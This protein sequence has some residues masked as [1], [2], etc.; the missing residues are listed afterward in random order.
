MTP[1]TIPPPRES[2]FTK[3]TDVPLHWAKY[4]P[5]GADRLLVLHGGPG[6]D[7]KYLLP[8]ML[9]LADRYEMIFYDQRGGGES[10][11]DGRTPIT[12]HTQ[13]ADLDTLVAEFGLEPLT[14][15]GYSWGA[16]LAMLYAIEAAAHRT[17]HSPA[18]LVLI[19]PAPVNREYR[20]RFEKELAR[21]NAAPTVAKAREKLA[22][23]GLR[24][25]DTA[26]YRE[27][28]FVLSVAGYFADPAK[29]EDMSPFRVIGRT[30]NSIW[31]S[32][33]DFDLLKPNQLDTVS[34][35]TLITHGNEDPIPIESSERA[36]LAMGA[37]VVRIP[38]S[39]HVPYVEEPRP[40]FEAIRHFLTNTSDANPR[41]PVV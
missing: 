20:D 17:A 28:A 19:D 16:L 11:T 22:E 18:R 34:V 3:T 14:V 12:W 30:Q 29:A 15:V 24:E 40:L 23:S 33:G 5:E 8:G 4:G 41:V 35:P 27:R 21:R 13:V 2:G 31:D 37:R 26:A 6:A 39:G 10:R 36:A 25:K 38:N 7:Y 32:L 1:P 9:A